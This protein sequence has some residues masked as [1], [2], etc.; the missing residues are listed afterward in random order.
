M[1]VPYESVGRLVTHQYEPA[2]RKPNISKILGDDG[3]DVIKIGWL[4]K[5]GVETM[6]PLS[7]TAEQIAELKRQAKELGIKET[8]IDY[9][10]RN[11]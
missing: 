5:N 3:I 11:N 1:S 6:K 9:W 2:T 4:D 7:F 10:I 8:D